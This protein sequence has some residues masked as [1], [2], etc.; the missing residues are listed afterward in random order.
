MAERVHLGQPRPGFCLLLRR[1]RQV[2]ATVGKMAHREEGETVADWEHPPIV[3]AAA[4]RPSR[5]P[6]SC[7]LFSNACLGGRFALSATPCLS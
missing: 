7:F 3:G 5:S 2:N 4:V 1:V 6:T